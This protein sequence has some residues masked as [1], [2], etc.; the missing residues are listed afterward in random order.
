[1]KEVGTGTEG[2]LTLSYSRAFI[3]PFK[4]QKQNSCKK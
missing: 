1:M 4:G 2:S 3:M